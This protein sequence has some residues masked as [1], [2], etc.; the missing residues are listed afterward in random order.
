MEYGKE[1][2]KLVFYLTEH[3]HAKFLAKIYTDGIKQGPFLKAVMEAYVNDDPN[4]MAFVHD[5]DKFKIT[6]R[7]KEHNMKE[8]KRAAL[9]NLKLNL[10]QKTIDDIF[11]I[12]EK[13]HE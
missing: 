1:T 12:L 2:K 8:K 11:D 6:K 3:E 9:L 7:Q 5:N 13:E 4:I 10:D